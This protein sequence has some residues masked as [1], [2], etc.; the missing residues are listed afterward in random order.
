M[1]SAIYSTWIAKHDLG[2]GMK[3]DLQ[4]ALFSIKKAYLISIGFLYLRIWLYL[5]GRVR[6]ALVYGPVF[7]GFLGTH[8]QGDIMLFEDGIPF[9]G[10]QRM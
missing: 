8:R 2:L 3:T 4:T 10:H 5:M 7:I 1:T 9:I 6:A